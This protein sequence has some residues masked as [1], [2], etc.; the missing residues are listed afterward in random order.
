MPEKMNLERDTCK[1][2]MVGRKNMECG[3]S[4]RLPHLV[5]FS[6]I[7]KLQF[8]LFYYENVRTGEISRDI[9]RQRMGLWY[10]FSA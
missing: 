6:F 2:L 10:G 3:L 1:G 8:E 9:A 4:N 5:F 7:N